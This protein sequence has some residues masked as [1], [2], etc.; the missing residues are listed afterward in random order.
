LQAS[1]TELLDQSNLIIF[2]AYI[3]EGIITGVEGHLIR[4][5][6]VIYRGNLLQYKSIY[7]S[8]MYIV[9]EKVPEYRYPLYY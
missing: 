5:I 3:R 4:Y 7:S 9:L 2:Y 8:C 1:S 6:S